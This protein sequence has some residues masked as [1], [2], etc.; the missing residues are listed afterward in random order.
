MGLIRC[1]EKLTLAAVSLQEIPGRDLISCGTEVAD[2]RTL[3]EMPWSRGQSWSATEAP[4]PSA[5]IEREFRAP[6]VA[7]QIREVGGYWGP[8]QGNHLSIGGTLMAIP[9]E[10]FLFF[11]R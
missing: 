1:T 8:F 11:R 3:K 7:C 5:N 4:K 2:F 9:K 10:H 6:L